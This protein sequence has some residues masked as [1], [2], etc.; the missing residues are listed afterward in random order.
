VT[1][2]KLVRFLE[3]A[4]LRSPVTDATNLREEY[5]IKMRFSP[6]GLA[7]PGPTVHALS[8]ANALDSASTPSPNLFEALEQQLGLKLERTKAILD[9]IVVDGLEEKPTD[10]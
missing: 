7:L 5:D 9:V 6:E 4:Y 2:G 8:G 3:D 1:L 10:N